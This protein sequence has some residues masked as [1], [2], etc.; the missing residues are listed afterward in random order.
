MQEK[1][2]FRVLVAIDKFKDSL[3]AL[4]LCKVIGSSF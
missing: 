2:K 1:H 4:S 3:D